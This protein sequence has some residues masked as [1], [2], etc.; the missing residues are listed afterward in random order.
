VHIRVLCSTL[1]L[2][3]CQVPSTVCGEQIHAATA[4]VQFVGKRNQG[5]KPY[6]LDGQDIGLSRN[7]TVQ[8]LLRV[9]G[10]LARDRDDSRI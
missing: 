5:T 1:E 2:N 4:Q 8:L 10:R 9:E 6:V 7:C 3:D